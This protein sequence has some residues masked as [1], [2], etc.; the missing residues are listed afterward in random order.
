METSTLRKSMP[1]S[2]LFDPK[3]VVPAIGSAFVKLNP[4]TLMANPVMFVLE[5]VTALTTV[6]LI[7]DLFTG[8]GHI[9]FE[10]QIV[11]WL[12]FTVLFANFAEAV[13]EGRGK[14][15]ADALRRQRTETQA[16]LLMAA[17]D[18]QKYRLVPSTDLKVGN[19]VLVEAGDTIP[20]DG[21]VVEGQAVRRRFAARRSGSP[22][23]RLQEP[24]R[25]RPPASPDPQLGRHRRGAPRRC[26]IARP[27]RQGQYRQRRLGGW[28]LLHRQHLADPRG[29]LERH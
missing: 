6:V 24:R 26:V 1:V 15:Q 23:L 25:H 13:A 12:W 5:I 19:V 11:L 2:A 16:K 27:D 20:M 28:E 17:G 4:R 7:R 21:E 8:G 10:F 29:T 9:L 14:A 3:I 18:S 22:G